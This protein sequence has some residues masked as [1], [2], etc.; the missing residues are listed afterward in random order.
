LP[1]RTF[2][3][4][5]FRPD[6]DC[7]LFEFFNGRMNSR[8]QIRAGGHSHQRMVMIIDRDFRGVTSALQTEDDV[9][10]AL[11]LAVEELTQ[12]SG[13][14]FDSLQ[15]RRSQLHLPARICDSHT[16]SR[17]QNAGGRARRMPANG[18]AA[19]DARTAPLTSASVSG[20]WTEFSCLRDIS[21]PCAA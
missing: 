2:A 8:G 18:T 14:R 20:A 3:I 21:Q 11:V 12:L 10:F 15:L 6:F 17:S 4:P 7:L 19:A 13:S 16:S 9:R 5:P 1:R